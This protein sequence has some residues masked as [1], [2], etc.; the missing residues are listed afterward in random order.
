MAGEA[1]DALVLEC[2]PARRKLLVSLKPAL[3]GSS[4]P[5]IRSYADA[6]PGTTSHG[7]V[8][9]LRPGALVVRFLGGVS[10]AVLGS[11][12]RATLGA[13][14]RSREARREVSVRFRGSRARASVVRGA[15]DA[16]TV[17]MRQ[18]SD[19]GSRFNAGTRLASIS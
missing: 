6:A 5:R 7:V 11:E 12:L 14:C 17:R 16:V 10:G 2:E 13:M 9:A 8:G 1:H 18:L 4:L 19:F 15:P 3:L